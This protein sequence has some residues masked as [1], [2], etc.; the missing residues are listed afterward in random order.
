MSAK[1]VLSPEQAHELIALYKQGWSGYRLAQR[2]HVA[3]STVWAYL[4]RAGVPRR[5]PKWPVPQL[6]AEEILR[7]T[8][9]AGRGLSQRQIAEILG[10][11]QTTVSHRL[12]RYGRKR[13][14]P[15]E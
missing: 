4:K 13:L 5:T 10:I 7:T 14:D 15:A 11:H 12:R 9:L 6:P 2:Y 8:E 3:S 1:P